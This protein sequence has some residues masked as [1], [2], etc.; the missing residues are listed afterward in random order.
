MGTGKARKKGTATSGR[1]SRTV[2][3]AAALIA[4]LL[5]AGDALLAYHT[6]RSA[7]ETTRTSLRCA[8]AHMLQDELGSAI[9][10]MQ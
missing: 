9:Q 7:L 3:A 10:D 4:V 5:V 1:K 2:V 8:F 6:T